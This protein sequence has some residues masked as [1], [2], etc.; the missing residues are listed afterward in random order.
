MVMRLDW[1]I[2]LWVCF[3]GHRLNTPSQLR[4]GMNVLGWVLTVVADLKVKLNIAIEIRD[5]IDQLC[6]GS[7]YYIFLEKLV[8]VFMKLLEGPPVFMSLA[9]EHV[10]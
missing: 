6:I 4:A 10:C 7:S 2:L 3:H 5:N 9:W 1:R 8:P